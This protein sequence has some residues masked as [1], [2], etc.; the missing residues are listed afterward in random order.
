MT[1]IKSVKIDRINEHIEETS[2]TVG[3]KV[4]DFLTQGI[5]TP[6][7]NEIIEEHK[8]DEIEKMDLN[9]S[10]GVEL[11]EKLIDKIHKETE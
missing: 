7:L 8:N 2:S 4:K 1:G 11:I 3:E 5:M 9:S 10:S 6:G